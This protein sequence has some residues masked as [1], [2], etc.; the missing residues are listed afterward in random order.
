MSFG[1][2]LYF[3]YI[4]FQDENWLKYALLYWD[5][6]KRIVPEDFFTR[7]SD[8]VKM[9]V[10][11]GLVENVN[12]R[13][14]K[15][16]YIQ[17]AADE[18]IPTMNV[19]IQKHGNLRQ[20]DAIR[21]SIDRNAPDASVH[22]LKM[23]DRVMKLLEEN[24][25]GKRMGEWFAMPESMAGYYMLCLAAHIGEKQNTPLLSDSPEMETGGTFF[26]HSRISPAEV[27]APDD[28]KGFSLARM[29][30]PIPCPEDLSAVPMKKILEFNKKSTDERM[31]FRIAIE[32]LVEDAANLDDPSAVKDF[33][34]EKK[35]LIE[36]ALN[37][38]KKKT[39]EL[40]VNMIL[41]LSS[42]SVPSTLA[43]IGSMFNPV[44]GLVAAGGVGIAFA[45]ISWYAKV[46]ADRRK[47]IRECDWHYLF[48][49][50]KDL[51]I[52]DLANN[53]DPW[54]K[55]FVYD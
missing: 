51:R 53:A 52:E 32:A 49:V 10:D 15:I 44:V 47:A 40:G 50:Q 39:E 27:N 54:M 38:Q 19:L 30:L 6:I 3:P 37:D 22:V 29:V 18:F 43:S 20:A 17:G 14:G 21:N 7:D 8:S 42:I 48:T 16:P 5:G 55:Q 46:R 13:A 25:L 36:K 34:E 2:A 45:L 24:M 11:N 35:K 9:L 4:H 41:S 23:D 28:D 31:Q 1:K 33:M 26:Q 12:P